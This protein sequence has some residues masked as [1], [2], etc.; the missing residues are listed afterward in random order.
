MSNEPNYMLVGDDG[1]PAGFID[2]DQIQIDATKLMYRQAAVAGDDDAVD[3]VV[4]EFMAGRS[5]D[6]IGYVTAAALSLMTRHVVAPM[7]EVMKA[8]LPQFAFRSKL[9]EARDHAEETLR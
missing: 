4:R 1:T 9:A 2:L 7:L 8:V 6:E 5:A 3:R